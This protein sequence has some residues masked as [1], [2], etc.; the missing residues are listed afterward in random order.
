MTGDGVGAVDVDGGREDDRV[1][2]GGYLSGDDARGVRG[3]AGAAADRSGVGVLIGD[4]GGD[5]DE[6]DSVACGGYLF[7]EDV[8]GGCEGAEAVA[9]R[10]DGGVL[11][12]D[13]D[14]GDD[15]VALRD[16]S[17]GYLTGEDVHS[18]ILT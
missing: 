15:R 10:D 14:A 1:V 7:E 8:R 11:L 2:G 6:D 16:C 18:V 13:E 3:G 9:N 5:V 4:G 17:E 12:G